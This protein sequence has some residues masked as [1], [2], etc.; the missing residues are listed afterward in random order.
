MPVHQ[1]KPSAKS[2]EY[3]RL[4]TQ[5]C[6]RRFI[7]ESGTAYVM[8]LNEA[9]IGKMR[10]G[11]E[12]PYMMMVAADGS[13]RMVPLHPARA[14]PVLQGKDDAPFVV[15]QTS[16]VGHRGRRTDPN[17]SKQRLG[18]WIANNISR[19]QANWA[20]M[21]QDART[22]AAAELQMSDPMFATY[23]QSFRSRAKGWT[24]PDPNE[25]TVH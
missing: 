19:Y 12:V 18:R 10:D 4:A 20:A 6:G 1:L 25:E 11:S 7:D 5:L 3:T 23:Y 8:V 2:A 21:R 13:Q 9:K 15:E 14:F 22:F 17:S 16:T 24:L